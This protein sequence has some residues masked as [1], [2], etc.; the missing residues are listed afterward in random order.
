MK[1]RRKKQLARLQKKEI[2]LQQAWN[3]VSEELEKRDRVVWFVTREHSSMT[4]SWKIDDSDD[5]VLAIQ[6][7]GLNK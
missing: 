6:T 1:S 4:S 5:N 7:H 3:V 2:T